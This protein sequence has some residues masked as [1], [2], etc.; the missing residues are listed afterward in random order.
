M[1][2]FKILKEKT[3]IWSWRSRESVGDHQNS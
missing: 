2:G 3:H 1:Q